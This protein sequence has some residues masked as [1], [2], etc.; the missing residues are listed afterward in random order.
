MEPIYLDNASTSFPKPP[1]VAQAMF[2]YVTGCGCNI[3]RGG[4]EGAYQAEETVLRTRQQLCRLF[5]GPDSRCVA[6]TK[7]ITESLNVLLKGLLRPGDHVLVSAMEHNAVMRPLTQLT[8]RGVTFDR[9]PCRPDGTLMTERLPGLLRENTR[10]V[11]MLHASNVCGTLLPAAEVGTFCRENG[12]LFLLDTAQTAGAFPIDMEA[13]GADALAFTGHKGLLGPQGI[14]GM[15]IREDFAQQIEPLLSGG[16]GSV[17]DTEFMPHFLPDR[18]ESGTMNLPGIAGLNAALA[19][20]QETGLDKI[21][22][23]E[24]ALCARFL[25]GARTLKNVRIAGIDGLEG[26]VATV[27]LD[28]T[29]AG[30]DNAMVSFQLD[31]EYGIMTRCGM[32][33]APRAHK[34]LGTFPQ[35]TVRFAFGHRNTPQEVD[36]C[37]EA[38]E[39]ILAG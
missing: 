21:Y 13:M 35:G 29:Q 6:F 1:Q 28:F 25:A 11:V 23:T 7:N 36:T 22:Q 34:T 38:L 19:Y 9:I 4:Y 26:R 2:D 20:I 14:G 17:S 12:L 32:H 39:T 27:S 5:H 10:A 16:T 37:L 8:R 31:S 18:F 15:V 3:G 30:L 24:M 33:C